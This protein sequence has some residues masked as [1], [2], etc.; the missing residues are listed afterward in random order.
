MSFTTKAFCLSSRPSSCS[1][2]VP[3]VHAYVNMCVHTCICAGACSCGGAVCVP[4][5]IHA[6]I[7][8]HMRGACVHVH[9]HCVHGLER[10]RSVREDA[11]PVRRHPTI[12]VHKELHTQACTHAQMHAN[13]YVDGMAI[14]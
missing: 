4:V 3:C 2:N 6:C 1:C 9:V 14:D 7:C 8:M 13:A 5:P 12:E 10:S 11:L